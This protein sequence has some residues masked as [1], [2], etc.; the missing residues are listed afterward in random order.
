[1]CLRLSRADERA[2]ALAGEQLAANHLREEGLRL[3]AR[4]L[5]TSW[6]EVDLVLCERETLVLAEVKTGRAG[7]RFRPGFRLSRSKLA[8]LKRA[9]EALAGQRP[10]RV[11]LIEVLVDERGR[12]RV[13]VHRGVQRPLQECGP[14][15]RSTPTERG[16]MR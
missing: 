6:G 5:L 3:L 2:F 15:R 1:M 7:A 16:P 11:D 10:H 9:G 4:R 12:A 13:E 8:S 14:A